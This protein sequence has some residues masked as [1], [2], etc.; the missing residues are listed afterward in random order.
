MSLHEDLAGALRLIGREELATLLGVAELTEEVRAMAVS[1]DQLVSDFEQYKTD[2]DT[3]L[4]ELSDALDAAMAQ[5]GGIPLEVQQKLDELDATV[6]A[7]DQALTAAKQQG[8]SA[9]SGT[10]G[11]APQEGST[12][13][14]VATQAE[15]TGMTTA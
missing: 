9:P 6:A 1:V 8:V 15:G 3:K 2:V 13:G 12:A 4:S 10:A 7:A 11:T 5:Q 14:N